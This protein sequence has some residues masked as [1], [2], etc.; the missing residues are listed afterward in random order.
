MLLN[1]NSRLQFSTNL[2]FRWFY[3]CSQ[4]DM[5]PQAR[6]AALWCLHIQL[7]LGLEKVTF[8]HWEK[9]HQWGTSLWI[10][11]FLLHTYLT[12][13]YSISSPPFKFFL[14]QG[15]LLV[16]ISVQLMFAFLFW[17]GTQNTREPVPFRMYSLTL[18][19]DV[20]VLQ[21]NISV[22]LPVCSRGANLCI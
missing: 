19:H 21:W 14:H 16:Q 12:R 20:E 5:A 18:N 15:P 3:D 1:Q 2:A 22:P 17:C 7:W 9:T 6:A 4:Q 11:F 8:C 13:L 10:S